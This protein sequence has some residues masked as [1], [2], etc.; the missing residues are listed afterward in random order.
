MSRLHLAPVWCALLA[1]ALFAGRATAQGPR[2][3]LELEA[4]GGYS[5]FSDAPASSA[6]SK[7]DGL[8]L[9]SLD[10]RIDDRLTAGVALRALLLRGQ[11]QIDGH[12]STYIY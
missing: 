1:G 3:V 4:W 12:Q 7:A 2:R 8:G 11:L 6:T 9:R 10:V 5:A